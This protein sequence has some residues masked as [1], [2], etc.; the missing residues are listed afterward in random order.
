MQLAGDLPASDNPLDTT[1][2]QQILAAF[3]TSS[4]A[5]MRAKDVSHALGLA[6]SP[7]F[8]RHPPQRKRLVKRQALTEPEPGLFTLAA[9]APRPS[10]PRPAT[11]PGRSQLV[12]L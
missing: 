2:C 8:R 9:Q 10:R 6:P 4:T 11:Q 1:V 12:R 7:K 5:T 3:T